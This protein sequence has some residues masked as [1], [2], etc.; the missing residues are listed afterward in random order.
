MDAESHC[1]TTIEYWISCCLCVTWRTPCQS[2]RAT[3][4]Y[5]EAKAAGFLFNNDCFVYTLSWHVYITNY[6]SAHVSHT[7]AMTPLQACQPLQFH[8]EVYDILTLIFQFFVFRCWQPCYCQRYNVM[9]QGWSHD[10]VRWHMKIAWGE[11]QVTNMIISGKTWSRC[12]RVLLQSL[13]GMS[14]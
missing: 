3:I 8:Q 9:W 4:A 13:T 7:A 12:I 1:R 2:S 5:Q 11:T 6:Y 14:I 10:W